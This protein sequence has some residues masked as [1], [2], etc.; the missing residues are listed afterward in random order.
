MRRS[1]VFIM[2]LLLGTGLLFWSGSAPAQDGKAAQP[3]LKN[4]QDAEKQ[5]RKL[6]DDL[7]EQEIEFARIEDRLV[8]IEEQMGQVGAKMTAGDRDISTLNSRLARRR[9]YLSGRVR[10]L[11]MNRQ[12][13]I[14]QVLLKAESI[15]DLVKRYRYLTLILERDHQ[16]LLDFAEQ[17]AQLVERQEQLAANRDELEELRAELGRKKDEYGQV[18]RKKMALLMQ[19]HNKKELYLAMLRRQEDS[20]KKLL[21]EVA[22]D[23]QTAGQAETGKKTPRNWPDFEAH[24]GKI[25]RPVVGKITD[26]FG[27]APGRYNTYSTRHG[28]IFSVAPGAEIK[29]V[30][31]GEVLHVGWLKGFGNI[32]IVNHGNRYYTLTGGLSGITP[33]VGQWVHQGEVIGMVPKGGVTDKKEIYFEIRHGGQALDPA[34]WLG[35]RP[36]A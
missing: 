13:G 1:T 24:K 32:I 20:H 4:L 7:E 16:D 36:V 2:L 34:E 15:Q 33:Q 25:P 9:K 8:E 30:M 21:K 19:V 27:R 14:L 18:K 23:N 5:E 10:A 35:S 17:K 3:E 31:D 6:L 12:G 26:R 11:Y 22:V 29:A 28:I